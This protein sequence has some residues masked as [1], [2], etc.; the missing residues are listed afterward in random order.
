MWDPDQY[1]R[2]AAERDRPF[3]D[4]L[5]QVPSEAPRTVADLGCGPGNLTAT[6]AQ[7][8]PG[9]RV[10]GVDSSAEMLAQAAA[11]ARPR[12]LD[13]VQ[14]D[15]RE[16]RP[17]APLDLLVSNAALQWVPDHE[18]LLPHLAALVAPGGW[19]AFQMPRNFDSPSHTLL[20]EMRSGARW[21][22]RLQDLRGEPETTALLRQD[23]AWYAGRL[24]ALGFAVN[25]WETEYLHLLPGE[26]AVL[27]WVKGTALR[28]VLAALDETERPAFLA[29]YGA[30]LRATYPAQPFGTPF[31][32][33][34][35]FVVARRR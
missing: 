21:A 27:E 3:H 4:L 9:A 29:E 14:A 19:L 35:L 31:P 8:W 6:L 10:T 16:W 12:R 5:A 1:R 7:R 15:L 24:S 26:D 25:A 33:R 34:R 11:L 17:E 23:S 32:F 2:Y 18:S 22:A 20:A 13:F 30:R 28:P